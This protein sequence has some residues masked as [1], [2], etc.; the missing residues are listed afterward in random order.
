[1]KICYS[2]KFAFDKN[3]ARLSVSQQI[4]KSNSKTMKTQ[5]LING[6]HFIF[7]LQFSLPGPR[8]CT[9][10]CHEEKKKK[11]EKKILLPRFGLD[12]LTKI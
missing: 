8:S 3:T 6:S 4:D 12:N 7:L 9:I 5:W 1:M 2:K 11:T 10:K